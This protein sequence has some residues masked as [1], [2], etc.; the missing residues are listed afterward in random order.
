MLYVNAEFQDTADCY[1]SCLSYGRANRS[2][3]AVKCVVCFYP[4]NMPIYVQPHIIGIFPARIPKAIYFLIC[5]WTWNEIS[6]T[7]FIFNLQW[8]FFYPSRYC[9]SQ[10]CEHLY[11]PVLFEDLISVMKYHNSS[12]GAIYTSAN[13]EFIL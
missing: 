3:L 2:S 4:S 5:T 11:L 6:G 13:S 12:S 9:L 1:I 10:S 7:V 8:A